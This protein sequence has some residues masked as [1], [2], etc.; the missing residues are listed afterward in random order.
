MFESK[1]FYNTQF[2]KRF[3]VC[4]KHRSEVKTLIP[5]TTCGD[6]LLF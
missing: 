3:Y 1:L 6:I 4:F 5:N 2:C